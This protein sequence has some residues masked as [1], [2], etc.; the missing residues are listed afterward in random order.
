MNIRVK[1]FPI[2]GICGRTQEEELFLEKGRV[3]EAL[4]LL[5]SRLGID[6]DLRAIE[7]LMLMHNGRVMDK[8]LD[9][10]LKEGDELWLLPP[11][12]GG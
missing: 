11:L 8:S 3:G 10:N 5:R 2:A 7:T 12:S 4:E 9:E 6:K 1:I